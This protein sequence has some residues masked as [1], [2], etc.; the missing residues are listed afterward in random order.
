MSLILM[1]DLQRAM[2]A[3]AAAQRAA[4]ARLWK[5]I[6]TARAQAEQDRRLDLARRAF[7]EATVA[8]QFGASF[9]S[10]SERGLIPGDGIT[11]RKLGSLVFEHWGMYVGAGMVVDNQPDCVRFIPIAEFA[12]GLDW[13]RQ[14]YVGQTPRRQISGLAMSMVGTV[15][16]DLV[17]NNCEQFVRYCQDGVRRSEQQDRVFLAAGAFLVIWFWR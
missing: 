16:Y 7:A 1:D 11:R 14:P 6:E 8:D 9:I 12:A 5:T 4:E 10:M 2:D 17:G 13:Q 3:A 15:Q